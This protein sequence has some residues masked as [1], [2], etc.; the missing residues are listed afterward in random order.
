MMDFKDFIKRLENENNRAD[1]TEAQRECNIW[2]MRWLKMMNSSKPKDTSYKRLD[3][4][5]M[6]LE[7]ETYTVAPNRLLDE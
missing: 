2:R 6:R 7:N 3:P 1:T 5:S 4:I